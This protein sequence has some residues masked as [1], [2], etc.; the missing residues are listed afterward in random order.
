MLEGIPPSLLATRI[1]WSV[2]D[3]P[4]VWFTANCLVLKVPTGDILS[5]E[6]K[7]ADD[8]SVMIG[9]MICTKFG[10]VSYNDPWKPT[11]S[12]HSGCNHCKG[13]GWVL[14]AWFVTSQ[15][16]WGPGEYIQY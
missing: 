7:V 13:V 8:F 12:T 11:E 6:A 10:L 9:V 5:A 16:H 1:S 15:H 2:G 4:R 3:L 14:Q